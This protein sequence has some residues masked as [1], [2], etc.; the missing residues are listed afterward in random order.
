MAKLLERWRMLGIEERHMVVEEKL[1]GR[2]EEAAS[3]SKQN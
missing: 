3:N 1:R 2:I